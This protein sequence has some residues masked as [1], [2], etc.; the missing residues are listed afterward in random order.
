MFQICPNQLKKFPCK[1]RFSKL[2]LPESHG[3]GY[4][5]KIVVEKDIFI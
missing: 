5:S 1:T 4:I 3:K 2:L